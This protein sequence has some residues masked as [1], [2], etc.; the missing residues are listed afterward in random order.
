MWHAYDADGGGTAVTEVW[1]L[2][3]VHWRQ[4]LESSSGRNSA[5]RAQSLTPASAPIASLHTFECGQPPA[6]CGRLEAGPTPCWN[7]STRR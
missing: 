1:P 5:P 4:P 6:S 2:S 3:C 7:G